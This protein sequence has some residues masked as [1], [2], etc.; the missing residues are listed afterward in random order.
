MHTLLSFCLI[1]SILIWYGAA[2]GNSDSAPKE[3]SKPISFSKLFSKKI[4]RNFKW[5]NPNGEEE[6]IS[7]FEM[8]IIH[9][10]ETIELV[11]TYLKNAYNK[12]EKMFLVNPKMI[13][14]HSMSLGDLK[15]SLIESGFLDKKFSWFVSKRGDL[16]LGAHFMIE[17]DGTIYCLAPP[18]NNKAN[19]D[20][21]K[22]GHYPMKRHV[23][24]GNP[25]AIGIENIVPRVENIMDKETPEKEKKL[26]FSNL[27]NP[28]IKANAKLVRWLKTN[29]KSISHIFGHHQFGKNDFRKKLNK[30]K[31]LLPTI[32]VDG[33]HTS[34]RFDVG[35]EVLQKIRDKINN[36]GYKL[37]SNP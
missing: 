29:K 18:R 3:C 33:K 37:S 12:T 35:D 7:F 2:S 25:W 32:T 6:E 21:S 27:R 19:I 20:Y 10:N 8:E 5:T 13:V 28:Q 24:E 1:F 16:P 34:N 15:R 4:G 14:V 30:N 26:V 36:K 17:K 22:S 11:E 9:P 31:L 23:L